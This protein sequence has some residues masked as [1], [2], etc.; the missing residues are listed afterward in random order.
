MSND[1]FG[2]LC[3]FMFVS[4]PT[5]SGST[6]DKRVRLATIHCHRSECD[7]HVET[8]KYTLNSDISR[9]IYAEFS[10]KECLGL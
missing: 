6:R 3:F 7:D 9:R 10:F 1:V 5:G 8:F 2:Q 4:V